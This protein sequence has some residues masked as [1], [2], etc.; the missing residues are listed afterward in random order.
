MLVLI[1][2]ATF[3]E[4]TAPKMTNKLKYTKYPLFLLICLVVSLSASAQVEAPD[5][6]NLFREDSKAA[7]RQRERQVKEVLRTD[8]TPGNDIDFTAPKVDYDEESKELFG[9]GGVLISGDDIKVQSDEAQFNL[10]TKDA[11]LSGGVLFT[12]SDG[13]VSADRGEIN[14]ETEVGRF[15]FS[16]FTLEDGGYNVSCREAL[17]LSETEFSL[18]DSAFSTCLCDDDSKPWSINSTSSNITRGGYAH[19]YNTWI[20]FHGVPIFYSP[21]FFF[22]VKDE[23]QSGLL[24][25]T[26]GQSNQDGFQFWQPIF[27]V[28]DDYTDVTLTPFIEAESRYGTSID[29]RKAFSRRSYINSRLIYSDESQ[30]DGDLR[31][32]VTTG[33]FDPEFD[34]SRFGGFFEQRWSSGP[35][36]SIPLNYVADI[37]L[38]SDDLFLREIED[39]DIARRE[40]RFT[41][42]RVLLSAPLGSYGGAELSGEFNQSIRTD[43]DLIFQRLPE[44]DVSLYKSFRPLGYNRFGIKTVTRTKFQATDFVRS[45][46]FDGWRF[47]ANPSVRVPFRYKNYFN[48]DVTL[49]V[50][51][52]KYELRDETDPGGGPSSITDDSRVVP[53]VDYSVSTEIERVFDL[54]E[55]N[56]LSY[57]T[58]LGSNNRNTTLK[59]VKHTI[60]PYARYAYVPFTTQNNLPLFDSLDRQRERSLVTY[61]VRSALLGRFLP[62]D[63]SQDPIPELAPRVDDLPLLRLDRS[64]GDFQGEDEVDTPGGGF[65]L[66]KG[67]IRNLVTFDVRQ[68]YDIAEDRSNLDANRTPLSDVYSEIGVYPS[69]YAGFFFENNFN[70]EET[71]FASWAMRFHLRDDRGDAW[72]TRIT[73]VDNSVSQV[74]SGL[75]IVLT[76]QLRLAYYGRYDDLNSEFIENRAA[77]RFTSGCNCWKFDVGFSDQ[78]NPDNQQVLFNITLTG[79]GDLA[80]SLSFD[81]RQN[82]N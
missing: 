53:R 62:R 80:Q 67:H 9:A 72:Q 18:T 44:L 1:L 79:L 13:N 32:T 6:E 14:M 82:Q 66:R 34:E 69:Q 40:A 54:D 27:L 39:E 12:T 76:D 65:Q 10:E 68:S 46:G 73:H 61:G 31:G 35:E 77:I 74:E 29:F 55:G 21:Y 26:Y 42:S 63:G 16:R 11:A 51:L 36:A 70:T 71:E 59:R 30:R 28:I 33:L 78:I 43:D 60:E 22:P 19:T 49:G 8:R 38:I 52:T 4:Q 20:D 58:S 15:E 50:N 47:N 25:P 57:L 64:I 41:T 81:E 17:K 45:D 75:E 2:I 3:T 37:H 5:D 24:A 48:S 7:E 23:R 56:S